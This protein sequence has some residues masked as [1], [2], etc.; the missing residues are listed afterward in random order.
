VLGGAT[1]MA[2]A[3]DGIEVAQ[4]LEGGHGYR[5]EILILE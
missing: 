2:E 1:E 5:S 3:G 4:L